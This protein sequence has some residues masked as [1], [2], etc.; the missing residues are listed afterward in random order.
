MREL[1]LG[2]DLP[3][4]TAAKAL[5]RGDA[6]ALGPVIGYTLLRAGLIGAGLYAAGDRQHLVQHAV[7]A[8]VAVEI[9]VLIW[10]ANNDA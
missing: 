7:A 8:S 3:S 9:F 2:S 1:S 4:G 10:A 5:V 6:G